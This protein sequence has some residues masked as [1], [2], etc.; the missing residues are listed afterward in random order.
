MDRRS[1][2]RVLIADFDFFGVVGGAQTFYSRLVRRN[3]SISFS[4][5]TRLPLGEGAIDV[6]ENAEAIPFQELSAGDLPLA[7]SG[8]FASLREFETFEH[9]LRIALSVKGRSFDAVDVPSYY[10][11]TPLPSRPLRREGLPGREDRPGVAW[12]DLQRDL[13]RLGGQR[14]RGDPRHPPGGS[15]GGPWPRRTSDTASRGTTSTR[16]ALG[17]TR[18]ST[19]WTST[20]S[21]TRSSSPLPPPPQARASRISGSSAG[22]NASRAPTSSSTSCRGCPGRATAGVYLAGPDGHTRGTGTWSDTIRSRIDHLGL[23]AEYLGCL[24]RDELLKR[25]YSPGCLCIFP[26]RIDTFNL[27]VTE[28]VFRGVP[29]ALSAEVGARRFL[30]EEYPDLPLVSLDLE[31]LD[32]S[33]TRLEEALGDLPDLRQRLCD[34]LRRSPRKDPGQDFLAEIYGATP[35]YEPLGEGRGQRPWRGNPDGT[36]AGPGIGP[37]ANFTWETPGTSVRSCV[38]SVVWPND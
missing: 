24:P 20:I 23:D 3:P 27:A 37:G 7:L 18:G 29:T 4:Y 25:A 28:A 38:Q 9:A 33:A 35:R 2:L 21:S 1:G 22:S 19:T 30:G 11:C 17:A 34:C 5:L 6:P 14:D 32:A 31:D 12:M 16:P 8:R 36:R 13:R 26:S 15:S 10:P